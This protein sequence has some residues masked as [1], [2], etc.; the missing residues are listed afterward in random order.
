MKPI[1][2]QPLT[3]AIRVEDTEL[4][5][6]LS[7]DRT[8]EI[9]SFWQQINAKGQ[10]HRGEVFHVDAVIE[11]EKMYRVMLKTTD[12]A[13]YLHTIRNHIT[14]DEA[15]RVIFAAGLAETADGKFVFGEMG[16]HTAHPGRLQCA[17]G[18]LSFKDKTGPFFDMKQSVLRELQE[19]LAVE[20]K[21]VA[22][23]T[24][25]SIKSGGPHDSLVILHH[26]RLRIS[27]HKLQ[28]A[29]HAHIQAIRGAGAEPEFQDVIYLDSRKEKVDHFFAVDE[30]HL[31]DYL[32]PFLKQM[33]KN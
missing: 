14:D 7:A 15:C 28:E 8:R 3:K 30:R 18:G 4:A 29:Y 21:H 25:V 6:Q 9:E 26:V 27:A 12:Y 22:S 23:C 10:F 13:H 1:Q 20:E 17:G 33:A 2:L 32:E 19:E 16:N 5:V 24:P 31:E 11:E